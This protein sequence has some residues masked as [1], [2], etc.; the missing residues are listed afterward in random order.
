MGGC[1]ADSSMYAAFFGFR[2]LNLFHVLR[3]DYRN[4]RTQDERRHDNE[5][6][7]GGKNR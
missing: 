4:M 1:S 3:Q 7:V 6:K 5:D 2:R